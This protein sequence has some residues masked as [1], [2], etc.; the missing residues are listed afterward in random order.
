MST[1]PEHAD[2]LLETALGY[3]RRGWSIVPLR[4]GKKYSAVPWK[5]RQK[6]RASEDEVR[7]WF[8]SGKHTGLGVVL[9]AVSGHLACRDFDK[10]E[11]YHAW[12]K[13]YPALAERLPTVQTGRGYHVYFS[14]VVNKRQDLPDGI[15]E[16]RGEK[17]LCALPP[18]PHPSGSFYKWI[19]PLAD[20]PPPAIDP[21]FC[22]LAGATV[23]TGNDKAGWG[24]ST[25]STRSIQSTSS[26][27]STKSTSIAVK[28]K[29]EIDNAIQKT[30]PTAAGQR[31][32]KIFDYA[33]ALKA[34][35]EIAA[36]DAL[37][38]RPL[39]EQWHARAL[40]VIKTK[41][42]VETWIDFLE[43]WPKVHTPLDEDS[44]V[45][46]IEKARANPVEGF[47]HENE[48]LR[49]LVALCRELQRLKGDKCFFMSARKGGKAVDVDKDTAWRWLGLLVAE[50]WITLIE[51]GRPPN[52]ASRFR[53]TAP[54]DNAS[55]ETDNERTRSK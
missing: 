34:I 48:S 54:M 32:R 4:K 5:V 26:T 43:A 6:T 40:S 52:W 41:E 1:K 16:L 20:D 46:A 25:R 14:G 3:V 22:G 53:Y 29:K 30:L 27:K 39:V 9:G 24:Q 28:Y 44:I 17:C 36:Y 51:K 7:K 18:S 15:G 8:E 33:R 47:D 45:I 42:F 31:N 11:C 2:T 50:R 12:A 21:V 19:V 49:L 13:D 37:T 10:A 23:Q 55:T 38:L 35:P